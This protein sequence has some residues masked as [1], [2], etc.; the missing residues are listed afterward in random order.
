M[1]YAVR[2]I[3][4][5]EPNPLKS[6]QSFYV[7]SIQRMNQLLICMARNVF[8][9]FQPP[10]IN[11]GKVYDKKS[12]GFGSFNLFIYREELLNWQDYVKNIFSF[13]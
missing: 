11:Q 5:W 1:S 7:L 8:T 2:R 13:V 4:N 9:F 12:F 10:T 6:T 3:L